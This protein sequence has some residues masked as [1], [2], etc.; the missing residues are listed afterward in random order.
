MCTHIHKYPHTHGC[1]KL[2]RSRQEDQKSQASLTHYQRDG[3]LNRDGAVRQLAG[4]LTPA[5]DDGSLDLESTLW[6][7]KT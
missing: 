7:E 2:E 1:Y 6:E 5:P 4:K 3:L